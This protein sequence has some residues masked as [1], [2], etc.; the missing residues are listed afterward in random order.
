MTFSQENGGFCD[1]QS[2]VP[3][4]F[5][6]EMGDLIANPLL[7]EGYIIHIDPTS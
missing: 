3:N 7:D 1:V 6:V 5:S 2:I 4:I